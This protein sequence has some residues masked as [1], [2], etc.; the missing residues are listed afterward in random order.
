[1]R[2]RVFVVRCRLLWYSR[3]TKVCSR[4]KLNYKVRRS[5]LGQVKRR[6]LRSTE[7]LTQSESSSENFV[8]LDPAFRRLS[9]WTRMRT[10]IPLFEKQFLGFPETYFSWLFKM[11]QIYFGTFWIP[12]TSVKYTLSPIVLIAEGMKLCANSLR[13]NFINVRHWGPRIF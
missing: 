11:S 12:H 7:K 5:T 3:W 8:A 6:T 1:M 10:L 13:P 2:N 4:H 9:P